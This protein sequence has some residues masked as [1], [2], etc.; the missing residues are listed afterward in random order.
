MNVKETVKKFRG[1]LCTV[2]ACPHCGHVATVKHG[3]QG[4][5]RGRTLGETLAAASQAIAG[6]VTHIKTEH[7]EKL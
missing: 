3:R 5:R 2:Y 7:K 4:G 1:P 6:V